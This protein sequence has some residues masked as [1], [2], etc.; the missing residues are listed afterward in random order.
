MGIN[1]ELLIGV[2]DK[3]LQDVDRDLAIIVGVLGWAAEVGREFIGQRAGEALL[4]LRAQGRRIGRP[5]SEQA[6]RKIVDLVAGR[7]AEG[8]SRV[9]GMGY[10]TTR[11]RLSRDPD[12][13][14]DGGPGWGNEKNTRGVLGP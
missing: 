1:G 5:P 8:R 2:Q 3:R 4:R 9:V 10:R 14:P 13:G 11:R 7:P 12:E 6:G